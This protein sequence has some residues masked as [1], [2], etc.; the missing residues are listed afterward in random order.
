[1]L[2][3]MADDSGE[4][5]PAV[6]VRELLEELRSEN[7]AVG[8]YLA[9]VNSRGGTCRR[10]EEGGDQE[11]SLAVDYRRR[12]NDAAIRWPITAEILRGIADSYEREAQL[13]DEKAEQFRSGVVQ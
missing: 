12:A 4:I 11:R 9:L 13:E 1:M 7:I 3:T 8:V 10:P 5:R 6:V 2:G